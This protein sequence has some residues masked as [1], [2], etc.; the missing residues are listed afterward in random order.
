MMPALERLS[1][2]SARAA[3]IFSEA[4]VFTRGS[5]TDSARVNLREIAEHS[6]NLRAF[7]IKRAG[8]TSRLAASETLRFHVNGNRAQIQQALLQLI[9]NAEQAAAGTK[10]EVA[11]E[12]D[13]DGGFVVARVVDP[14][15]GIAAGDRERLFEPFV[16]T[17]DPWEGAGLGLWAAR[18][19]AAAHG[20][21]VVVEE[22]PAGAAIAMRL[23]AAPE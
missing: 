14:G 8:L 3:A 21:T 9:M 16:S 4:M 7:F 2:Q 23:P 11:V 20:G 17:R 22:R 18:S 19:I 10:G 6:L 13:I 1:K 5:V 12:L 15:P